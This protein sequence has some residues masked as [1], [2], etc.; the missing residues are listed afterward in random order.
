M[1]STKKQEPPVKLEENEPVILGRAKQIFSKS[2]DTVSPF[3]QAI[4]SML[5]YP[6]VSET[7]FI[8]F[9]LLF[10]N[11]F[12]WVNMQQN[13]ETNVSVF[14]GYSL[15]IWIVFFIAILLICRFLKFRRDQSL[16]SQGYQLA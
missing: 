7:L 6:L 10:A 4:R 8:L 11:R 9:A 5:A 12:F 14:V 2:Y 16:L 1:L 13:G 15:W 3:I